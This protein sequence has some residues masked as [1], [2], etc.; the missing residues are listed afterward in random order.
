MVIYEMGDI[1]KLAEIDFLGWI[2][3]GFMIMAAMIAMYTIVC[4]FCEMLGK[5]I[6]VLKQRKLDH[7]L[8]L[9]NAQAI[10]ELSAKHEEDTK[11]SIRHDEMIRNDLA[12]LTHMFVEKQIDDMRFEILDFA[13]AISLGRQYSKE[14]FDHV[15]TID[16]KYQKILEENGL[17]NGQVTASMEVI[18]EIYKEKLKNGF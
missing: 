12:N 3:T 2:I 10:K 6:G 4:K 7:E 9:Q 18:M 17:E 1:Q 16:K 14:Q 5:P 15:I 11:Q 13:S 8:T